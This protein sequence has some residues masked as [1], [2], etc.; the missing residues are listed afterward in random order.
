MTLTFRENIPIFLKA[1]LFTVDS[2]V[3][4]Y[5]TQSSGNITPTTQLFTLLY[6]K[7][8]VTLLITLLEISLLN[9]KSSG[10]NKIKKITKKKKKTIFEFFSDFG[11]VL[12]TCFG[13]I[14]TTLS[15]KC[16]VGGTCTWGAEQPEVGTKPGFIF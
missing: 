10:S 9:S 8:V 12:G 4:H 6:S 13:A 16:H 11:P 3:G 15:V 7:V 5:S 1:I 2:S 14:L